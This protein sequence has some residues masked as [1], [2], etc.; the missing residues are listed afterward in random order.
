MG[1]ALP[2]S[3]GAYFAGGC[4]IVVVTGDGSIMMN[5]QE[6]Q[7]IKHHSIPVKIIVVS[8]NVYAIIKQRQEGLFRSRTIGTNPQDGISCPDFQKVADCFGIAYIRIKKSKD[9]LQKLNEAVS[10][11][12]TVLCEIIGIEDQ[13][14]LHSS[15]TLDS[16]KKYV[17]RPI[18][19]QSPFL[20]RDLFL[21]EMIIDPIDQ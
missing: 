1:F 14:Y 4:Q 2:A 15:Y 6:L 7:T 20:D 13:K 10:M 17:K 8:N 18:E 3:I 16:K 11:R 5:L 21:S 12:E 9:L 19:D